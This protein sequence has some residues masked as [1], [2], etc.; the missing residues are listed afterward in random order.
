MLS[1]LKTSYRRCEKDLLLAVAS[2]LLEHAAPPLGQEPPNAHV[3]SPPHRDPV[4]VLGSIWIKG[5]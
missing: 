3:T 2:S 4:H 5:G 1:L